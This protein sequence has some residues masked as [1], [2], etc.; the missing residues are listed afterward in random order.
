M[1]TQ[2]TVQTPPRSSSPWQHCDGVIAIEP[3][4]THA[5]HT[6]LSS[7]VPK[8]HVPPLGTIDPAAEQHTPITLID[9]SQQR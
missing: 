9:P 6:P 8:Q 5:R 2:G 7:C 3:A 1:G 4:G